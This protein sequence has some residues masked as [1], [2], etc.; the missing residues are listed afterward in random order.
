MRKPT[1]LRLAGFT[2]AAGLTASLAGVAAS[3]TGAYFTDSHDGNLSGTAGHLR[4]SVSSTA[5]SFADLVPGDYQTRSI[6]YSTNSSGHEDIWMVFP[7][8]AGYSALT[9]YKGD[10]DFS[11][12][13]LGRYGHFAVANGDQVKFTSYNLQNRAPG[14]TDPICSVDANGN[15]GS[16]QQ[17]TSPT[18]TPPL[19]GVP[20]F[21]KL[22]S[23][24]PSGSTGTIHMT[25]GVT[26]KWT[27]QNVPATNAPF[28]IVATQAGVRPD[29]LNF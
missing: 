17:A 21:I 2:L 9:G 22:A 15:G 27:G 19:C 11:A 26:G 12:G 10:P 28:K 16:N 23:D 5:L 24:L 1:A 3:S 20:Q 4:L 18:D 7:S 6:D 13:G 8:G 14:A 25:F 29:A